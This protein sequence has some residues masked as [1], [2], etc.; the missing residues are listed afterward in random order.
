MRTQSTTARTLA[1]VATAALFTMFGA[2]SAF[3]QTTADEEASALT[4]TTTSVV[5]GV[6]VLAISPFLTTSTLAGGASEP[7]QRRRRRRRRRVEMLLQAEPVA[8]Q[9]AVA[10]GHGEAGA[11]LATLFGV[12]PENYNRFAKMLRAKRGEL[13]PLL[14]DGASARGDVDVADA[15]TT[16]VEDAMRQ[17]TALKVDIDRADGMAQVTPVAAPSLTPAS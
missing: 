8:L 9:Q 16:I 12:A 14:Q 6:T 1:A 15:F 5:I 10:V 11:D 3:A 13:M 7:P 2:T 17:D 4:S